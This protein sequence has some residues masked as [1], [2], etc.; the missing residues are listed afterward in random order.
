MRMTRAALRA[1]EAVE[2]TL[3]EPTETSTL[4]PRKLR[5][6]RSRAQIHEDDEQEINEQAELSED[7]AVRQVLR[8]ITDESYPQAD[9]YVEIPAAKGEGEVVVEV[10]EKQEL[11]QSSR[12]AARAKSKGRSSQRTDKPAIVEPQV[13]AEPE[14][15]VEKVEVDQ[16]RRQELALETEPEFETEV[17]NPVEE[18][19]SRLY[20]SQAD[21]ESRIVEEDPHVIE[22]AAKDPV[23]EVRES[24]IDLSAPKTPKFDPAVHVLAQEEQTAT[25][26]EEDSFIASIR[27]RSPAKSIEL[28]QSHTSESLNSTLQPLQT[29]R[30]TSSTSFEQSFEAMDSLEDTIE[31]LT[32]GLP[33]LPAANMDSPDSPVK[34]EIRRLNAQR[35][36]TPNSSAARSPMSNAKL[37]AVLRDQEKNKENAPPRAARTPLSKAR[38]PLKPQTPVFRETPLNATT[39]ITKPSSPIRV[40]ITPVVKRNS[41]SKATAS[42]RRIS[43]TTSTT[44][45]Q[46][47]PSSRKAPKSVRR[48]VAIAAPLNKSDAG[49]ASSGLSQQRKSSPKKPLANT[50]NTK[51][52]V[53]PKKPTM[54]ATFQKAHGTSLSFSNS[55][56]K[57]R[58]NMHKR[59]IT[60][61]GVLSTAKP[62]FIPAKSSK[63]PTSSTF[64]LPGEIIAEKLKVQKEAREEQMRQPKLSI[65]EQKAAKLK[66]ER[67][68]RE[69]RVRINQQKEAEAASFVLPGDA[70][71][72]KLRAERTAREEK[73]KEPKISLAEQKAAK[74]K[75][76]R[77]AREERVRLNQQKEAEFARVVL[78]G[79]AVAEKLR[80]QREARV[81]SGSIPASVLAEQKA[82]KLKA[83]REAREE[84]V[85]V[86]QLKA[87][88][89]AA[90]KKS[91]RPVLGNTLTISK[92]RAQ[93]A[94][95]GRQASKEW[96][97]RMLKRKTGEMKAEQSAIPC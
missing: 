27:S 45:K 20:E 12:R 2:E 60:S 65:A 25:A 75:A 28:A 16:H 78:P 95:R 59:R 35:A 7:V 30:R 66:A 46:P 9:S 85:R 44:P 23:Q 69:E 62:G 1:Q 96:A 29:L 56:A 84:R 40:R 94:E 76:E 52:E 51:S 8:D 49:L 80:A 5:K 89:E 43:S 38:T 34:M 39:P 97:E 21:S 90:R 50:T 32:A 15:Q 55:P 3:F 73:M 88:E 74:L 13:S 42:A 37:Q 61:G 48:S 83:E 64:K 14:A 26:S 70:V 86:N 72:E 6:T 18:L 58:P 53:L 67:E 91:A 77:E 92:A 31:S 71:A 68:A 54:A 19:E 10:D 17:E 36:A 33:T 63:P 93:A 11:R 41:P 57:P 4:E 24:T 47:P 87:E 82:A 79:D 22:P 81:A